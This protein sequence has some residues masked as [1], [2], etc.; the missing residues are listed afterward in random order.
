MR[1]E[2]SGLIRSVGLALLGMATLWG[3]ALRADEWSAASAALQQPSP[4]ASSHLSPQERTILAATIAL[5]TDREQEALTLLNRM[6]PRHRDPLLS[7]LK[8]EAHR[9]LALQALQHAGE[10]TAIK[11]QANMLAAADLSDG[12]GEADA[13]LH[14]FMATLD[15]QADLPFDVLSVGGIANVFLVDKA[16][17]RLYLFAPDAHGSLVKVRDEYVVTGA[18]AGDKQQRGDGKTPNGVYRFV[19]KLQ[20]SRLEARYGP[21]AFPIDYPNALDRLHR[22]SGNGI[23]LHGYAT[24]VSRRPPQDTRGCFSLSN[25]RLVTIASQIQLHRSWVIIGENLQFGH[26][27]EQQRLRD[28]VRQAIQA[29]RRDWASLNTAAYLSHYHTAFHSGGYDLAGW[30]R[31]KTRVNAHKSHIEV[32]IQHLSLIHDPNRWPE[33][34]VVVAEFDQQYRSSNF[35]DQSRKRLYLVRASADDDWKIL[36]EE[37]VPL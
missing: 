4:Q 15:R 13:R 14:A 6:H 5:K 34:E 29:W 31:Y 7:L 35:T 1:A 21:V 2:Y 30:R 26:Q 27:Q 25:D 23:W 17:S 20:G 28:S 18:V 24:H 10:V 3:G 11:S 22:K 16:R 33:G 19:D 36:I 12:L 8:A 32:R 37:S 9:K